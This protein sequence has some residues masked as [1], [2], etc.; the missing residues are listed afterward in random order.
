MS[1]SSQIMKAAPVKRIASLDGLRAISILMVIVGHF[2]GGNSHAVVLSMFGVQ[3]FFVLS[4]FLITTLLQQEY[5]K[6]RRID[7]RAFYRRRCFRIL[8]A[9][10][11][12]IIIIAIIFPQSRS[13]LPY[14]VTY[15]VSY[16]YLGIPILFQHLWS[17]SVEEQFYLLWPFLLLVGFRYRALIAWSAMLIAAAF[18]LALALGPSPLAM[19]YMHYTFPGTMDSIAAG[20]LLAIYQPQLRQRILW[21][22]QP[23]AI[24]IAVPL[25]AWT[26]AGACA[27]D[28]SNTAMRSLSALAGAV[29]LLIALWIFLLIERRDWFLNNPVASGIGVLSYSLYL[30]QQ[31]FAVG[32]HY[33]VVVSVLMMIVC[34]LASYFIVEAPMMRLGA[35]T[36]PKA[37]GWRLPPSPCTSSQDELRA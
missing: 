21:M 9:A 5:L 14:A 31:P 15:S 19:F 3:V 34:A 23:A 25:T 22:A 17:L 1:M 28:T 24:S 12:Y 11:A 8:P 33:S 37:A 32:R 7:V 16:H 13:G 4:G 10:Y 18:R 27:G 29:P 6:A 20:C 36:R 35:A 2:W 26:L 30:W